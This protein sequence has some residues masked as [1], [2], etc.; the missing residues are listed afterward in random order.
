MNKKI[1]LSSV[2]LGA[3]MLL[4][5]ENLVKNSDFNAKNL[6]PEYRANGGKVAIFTEE[7]GK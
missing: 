6:G 1:L 2:V 4:G 7:N 3:A 5:A